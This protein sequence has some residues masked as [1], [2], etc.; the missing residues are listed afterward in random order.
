[1][2]KIKNLILLIF[3]TILSISDKILCRGGH[4]LGG[5]SGLGRGSGN[6][7]RGNRHQSRG[8]ASRYDFLG[9]SSIDLNDRLIALGGSHLTNLNANLE[10]DLIVALALDFDRAKEIIEMGTFDLNA[11]LIDASYSLFGLAIDHAVNNSANSIN[12]PHALELVEYLLQHG[13]DVNAFSLY[14]QQGN[15]T[16][17]YQVVAGKPK[18]ADIFFKLINLLLGYGAKFN[19]EILEKARSAAY[20]K[21]QLPSDHH[22]ND[23]ILQM[24][25]HYVKLVL[26]AKNNPTR[27][28]LIEAIGY[29]KP[30]IVKLII[31]KNPELVIPDD[32]DFAEENSPFVVSM[33]K[34]ALAVLKRKRLKKFRK[35]E[36]VQEY[37]P[38]ELRNFV[39][40]FI[41]HGSQD[42]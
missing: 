15:Q 10:T 24:F 35:S 2:L 32:I 37:L 19:K 22:I 30:Y 18:D 17:L 31:D 12:V 7:G 5:R 42:K 20:K 26:K 39:E 36:I 21:L 9:G 28:E 3:L 23:A 33:L 41:L 16:P 13:A 4:G 11:K 40:K 34:D 29:N 1:M 38:E 6:C 25:I 27:N 14:T 8:D